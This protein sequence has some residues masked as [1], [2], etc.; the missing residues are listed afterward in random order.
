MYKIEITDKIIGNM[1]QK[2]YFASSKLNMTL[3]DKY[4]MV[5]LLKKYTLVLLFTVPFFIVWE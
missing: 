2:Q 4:A 1:K 5:R 3:F